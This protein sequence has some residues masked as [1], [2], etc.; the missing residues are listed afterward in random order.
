M[1]H[2][3]CPICWYTGF[4]D[5]ASLSCDPCPRCHPD[6][7]LPAPPSK[8]GVVNRPL[9]KSTIIHKT[10]KALRLMPLTSPRLT[11]KVRSVV[12]KKVAMRICSRYRQSRPAR[13]VSRS[14][15]FYG[16]AHREAFG[17][18]GFGFVHRSA[19]SVLPDLQICS[20]SKGVLSRTKPFDRNA[21]FPSVSDPYKRLAL[22]DGGARV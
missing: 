2:P 15:F 9:H 16:R 8:H 20:W 14:A 4:W 1:S 22:R 7:T 17:P 18:A 5:Y 10:K 19:N 11:P 12:T 13:P 3:K 6:L 21:I